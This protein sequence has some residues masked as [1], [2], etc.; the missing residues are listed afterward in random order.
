MC[1][2]QP[3]GATCGRPKTNAFR[4]QEY[5][6]KFLLHTVGRCLGAA[7]KKVSVQQNGGSKPPPYEL[8]YCVAGAMVISKLLL[9]TLLNKTNFLFAKSCAYL[10]TY[11]GLC[12]N[13]RKKG[14]V[15]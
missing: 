2:I 10:D 5:A 8:V 4:V 1:Q 6:T 9:R 3:V 12:Y 13:K 7:A 15:V 11:C 14:G